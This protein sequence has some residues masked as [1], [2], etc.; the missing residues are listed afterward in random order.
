MKKNNKIEWKP[1]NSKEMFKTRVFTVCEKESLSPENETNSFISLQAPDWVVVIP[2]FKDS[3]G[4]KQFIMV[5]QWRHGTE[6]V[7]IEF[8]GG[9]IDKGESP[10]SAARR[11]LLEE[12]GRS[13]KSLKLLS[14]L[15]PNPA[16]M[17]NH[18]H[19]FLAEVDASVQ[20]QN[21]DSDEFV[22][23]KTIPVQEV[24]QNMGKSGYEHA[25]MSAAACLYM[26]ENLP[27]YQ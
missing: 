19:I 20:A 11:E 26:R 8:P 21:L 24:L 25:I 12:T 15:S 18:C 4:D 23:V 27:K 7:F 22:N 3:N 13:A 6:S 5:E 1:L 9:V 17:E 14:V 2:E 16:I 10:E